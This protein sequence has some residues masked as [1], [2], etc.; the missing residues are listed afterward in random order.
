MQ[1]LVFFKIKFRFFRFRLTF[2]I[3]IVLQLFKLKELN[4][5]DDADEYMH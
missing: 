3:C 2:L 5:T 1:I 4:I